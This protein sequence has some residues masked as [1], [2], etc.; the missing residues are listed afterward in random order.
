MRCC[1]HFFF[2][3]SHAGNKQWKILM[4]GLPSDLI[5]LSWGSGDSI[6][7]SIPTGQDKSRHSVMFSLLNGWSTLYSPCSEL[8]RNWELLL[9][10]SFWFTS[11]TCPPKTRPSRVL[12]VILHWV[13]AAVVHFGSCSQGQQ[14][15]PNLREYSF[16]C[17]SRIFLLKC[18]GK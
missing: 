5:N 8:V 14:L 10:T 12:C 9:S 17:S 7:Y 11:R 3:L 2:H 4:A 1:I 6:A 15:T 13:V 16:S 18:H